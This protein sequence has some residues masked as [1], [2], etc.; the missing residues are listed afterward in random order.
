[1]AKMVKTACSVLPVFMVFQDFRVSLG[2]LDSTVLRARMGRQV[3]QVFR[4]SLEFQVR[5]GPLVRLESAKLA[6]TVSPVSWAVVALPVVPACRVCP[7]KLC[8]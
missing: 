4:A 1:M 2:L 7:V 5:P 6:K 8:G 3:R